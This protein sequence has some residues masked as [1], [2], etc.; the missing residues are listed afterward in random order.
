[1]KKLLKKKTYDDK[2]L[3]KLS[4]FMFN[5]SRTVA[6]VW[7]ALTVFGI[8]SYTTFLK[9][10]GFPSVDVPF[11]VVNGTYFVNNPAKVDSDVA[12]PIGKIVLEDERVSV[13]RSTSHGNFYAVVIQYEEGTNAATAGNE[14]KSKIEDAGVLPKQANMNF[15]TPKFGFTER[16]DDAVI[17]LFSEDKK[18][19]AELAAE[20]QNLA[21]FIK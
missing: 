11:S 13:V 5:H 19:T 8:F 6:L 1:M 14:I 18:T 4:L 10:E 21:K 17:S 20:G 9:R 2:L 15:T 12:K 16:G 3:P 7:L